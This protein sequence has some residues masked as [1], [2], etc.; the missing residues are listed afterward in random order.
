MNIILMIIGLFILIKCADWFVE[1]SSKLAKTF[2]I[3]S[4]IIGLTIVGF[5]T[6]AP[7]TSVSVIA[8]LNGMNDISIGNVVGSNIFNL[9]FILGISSFFGKITASKEV[10]KRDFPYAILTCIII[11]IFSIR[12]FVNGSCEGVISR[13]NGCILLI[14]LGI[15]LYILI[16]NAVSV[17]KET[18]TKFKIKNVLLIILGLIGIIIGGKI[19]VSCATKIAE[20]FNV[21]QTVIALTIVAIGTS[22]PEL[23]T[24]LVATKKGETDI[25]IGNVIGSNIYN[26]L[27]ILGISSIISPLTFKLETFIDVMIMFISTL[28]TYILFLKNNRLNK[29]K[30]II[31]LLIYV[32]YMIYVLMR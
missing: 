15:Y 23:V 25:A 21:S 2:G 5:G 6:S 3:P 13:L 16:K 17:S 20:M 22:L 28:L 1:G 18:K 31:L 26:I 24:S 10:I 8:S 27:F 7:E 19:V 9:L 29:N 11:I 30:G 32:V 4:L 14:F 12:F